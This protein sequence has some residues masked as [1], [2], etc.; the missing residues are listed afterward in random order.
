MTKTILALILA[1]PM[2][3]ASANAADLTADKVGEIIASKPQPL[4]T[5]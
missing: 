1:L 2:I 3:S 5:A 4:P